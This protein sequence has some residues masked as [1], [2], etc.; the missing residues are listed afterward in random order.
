M[1]NVSDPP[2]SDGAREEKQ[3]HD[4]N[5]TG[6]T[7][8]RSLRKIGL[9]LLLFCL[10]ILLSGCG[11]K[12]L[13]TF[14]VNGGSLVAG[15]LIQM[16]EEGE[17]AAAPTV[18]NGDQILSWDRDFS[19]IT[20]DA[21]ITAQWAPSAYTVCFDLNGG[22]LIS[23]ETEQTVKAGAAA[24]APEAVNGDLQ[25]T[26]DT[27]FSRISGDTVVTAQWEKMK[28]DENMEEMNQYVQERT[29]RIHVNTV[30]GGETVGAGFFIDE[31]GTVATTWKT[32]KGAKDISI[33]LSNGS[34]FSVSEIVD[35]DRTL[36][37]AI[38]KVDARDIKY[39][40]LS[41]EPVQDGEKLYM[42]DTAERSL[43]ATTV[44]RTDFI[45]GDEEYLSTDTTFSDENRGAPFVNAYGEVV[46]I[47]EQV[48]K[49]LGLV[50]KSGTLEKLERDKNWTVQAFSSW[51]EEERS[52]SYSLWDMESSYYE[53]TVNTYQAVT[54]RECQ[55]SYFG[56]E[57]RE[58][59]SDRCEAYVYLYD[60]DELAQYEAYL[61]EN[62]FICELR[63]AEDR[64][65]YI[66]YFNASNGIVI[67]MEITSDPDIPD[68]LWINAFDDN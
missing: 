13:I 49:E 59:Y 3:M 60:A 58:G 9:L 65:V 63:R 48:Y 61:E 68:L 35:F 14:D 21:I 57:R 5:A 37:L 1:A 15:K 34:Q 42:A 8:Y 2:L 64:L 20:E 56:D 41:G 54:G 31:N 24:V 47:S 30:S 67:H 38:L 25:L 29:V 27:D 22:E 12:Y 50:V 55:A 43:T 51:Y 17:A 10:C 53:S 19:S 16:V 44:L 39:L 40:K 45:V 18:E 23:G 36:D 11:K 4:Q 52:R 46:G 32:I 66:N 33:V 28:M 6:S 62:G 7:Q 26:W